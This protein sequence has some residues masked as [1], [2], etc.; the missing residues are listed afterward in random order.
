[1]FWSFLLPPPFDFAVTTFDR[2]W[3]EA[4][5]VP[6]PCTPQPQ[7]LLLRCRGRRPSA[8]HDPFFCP[9]PPP[10]PSDLRPCFT[11]PEARYPADS[12]HPCRPNRDAFTALKLACWINTVERRLFSSPYETKDCTEKMEYF[13]PCFASVLQDPESAWDVWQ[14]EYKQVC[15]APALRGPQ[16]SRPTRQIHSVWTLFSDPSHTEAPTKAPSP[17]K[18]LFS[19]PSLWALAWLRT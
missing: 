17:A 7:A 5:I 9:P 15:G 12:L 6:S 1:M 8:P 14:E 10:L 2:I 18:P 16:G 19:D 11:V 13:L 3:N 4:K